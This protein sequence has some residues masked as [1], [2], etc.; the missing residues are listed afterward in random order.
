MTVY[1]FGPFRLEKEQLLL[2]LED[3]PLALGPKVVETLLALVEH[4]GEVLG[5][6]ELLDRI[7]PDGFVEEANLAQNIYVIRKTLRAHWHGEAIETVPRRGYRFNGDVR[8][9]VVE[10]EDAVAALTPVSQTVR[11]RFNLSAVFAAAAV[12]AL[13]VTIPD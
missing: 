9:E 6:A 13:V 2:S 8:V 3:T 4:P 12:I 10:H 11:R 1:R 7:W 5:K